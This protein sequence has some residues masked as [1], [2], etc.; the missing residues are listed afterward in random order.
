MKLINKSEEDI[1]NNFLMYL[2]INSKNEYRIRLKGF[3]LPFQIYEKKNSVT[4]LK[5]VL[6]QDLNLKSQKQAKYLH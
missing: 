5:M 6:V 4:K 2:E 1:F 3:L